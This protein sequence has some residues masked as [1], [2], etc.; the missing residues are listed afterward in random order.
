MRVWVTTWDN[1]SPEVWVG[2]AD[3]FE[4]ILKDDL[5][6]GMI[7]KED[8]EISKDDAAS[9]K[10][11]TSFYVDDWCSGELVWVNE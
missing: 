10:L 3:V 11:I 6:N 1:R 9:P 8:V 4:D 5:A 7:E 2:A